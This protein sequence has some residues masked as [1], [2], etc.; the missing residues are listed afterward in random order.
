[1]PE[2]ALFYREPDYTGRRGN[3]K[4]GLQL[5]AGELPTCL[6]RVNFAKQKFLG[7]TSLQFA[8]FE[9][10]RNLQLRLSGLIKSPRANLAIKAE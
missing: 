7:A 1:M 4:S 2:I 6:S 10:T 8:A 5:Q 3:G 9:H